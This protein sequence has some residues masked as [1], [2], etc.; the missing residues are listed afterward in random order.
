MSDKAQLDA[1]KDVSDKISHLSDVVKGL[2]ADQ[3]TVK[4]ALDSANADG[5]A[6]PQELTDAINSAAANADAAATAADAAKAQ[7]DQVAQTAAPQGAAL[8]EPPAETGGAAP[9]T[10]STQPQ[11]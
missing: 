2:V 8:P 5:A 4:Q 6:I 10:D 11:G 1:L 9:V 3:A 7:A